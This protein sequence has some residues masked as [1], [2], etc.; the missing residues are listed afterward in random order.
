MHF[1]GVD[2]AWGQRRPTGVAVLDKSGSLVNIAVALDDPS[3]ESAL[4]PYV[5]GDCMVAVDAPLIVTNP[6]GQRQCEAAL[7]RDFR[8][9]EAG[10]HPCNTGKPECA[11]TPRGA[12]LAYNL[13]LD[14]DPA[15]TRTRRAVEVYP[16]PASVALFHLDRTLKYKQKR[17][18]TFELLKTEL[19][20]LMLLVE[21]LTDA[22]PAMDVTPNP[23]WRR[24]RSAVES[25]TRKF[26]LRRVEDPVDAVM[27]AYIAYYAHHRPD[28]MT[29]YGD[30]A[31]GYIVTPTLG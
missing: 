31:T 26:E 9:F 30:F 19:L 25:A 5:E 21:N 23:E 27:C 10:A 17:G 28:D 6:T 15:S 12:R 13:G 16:H 20:R 4:G 11:A 2:L 1:V 8:R 24:M 29:V 3:V 18:R 22:N 7:N 14:M